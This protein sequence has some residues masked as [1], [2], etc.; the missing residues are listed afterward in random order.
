LFGVG[1]RHQAVARSL[2]CL[3][4]FEDGS[5]VEVYTELCLE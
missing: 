5:G 3:I 2:P 4:S 1:W